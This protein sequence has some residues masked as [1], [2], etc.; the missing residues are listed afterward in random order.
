MVAVCGTSGLD[1]LVTVLAL[2]RL[3]YTPFLLDTSSL[4]VS[5]CVELCRKSK[6]K[7]Y[8]Y[9]EGI[10]L[11]QEVLESLRRDAIILPSY[12]LQRRDYIRNRPLGRRFSVQ[13]TGRGTNDIVLVTHSYG[14]EPDL[15]YWKNQH[16]QSICSEP[17]GLSCLSTLPL[18]NATGFLICLASFSS[19]DTLFLYNHHVPLEAKNIMEALEV[20][21]PQTLLTSAKEFAS[22]LVAGMDSQCLKEQDKILLRNYG[23]STSTFSES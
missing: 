23:F 5:V 7:A 15:T 10:P 8:I 9:E 3:G 12:L 18:C 1:Y 11:E 22:L 17:L 2:M 13:W 16:L 6:I 14:E 19:G 20:T 21:A 4:P